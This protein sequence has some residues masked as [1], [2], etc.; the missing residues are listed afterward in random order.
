LGFLTLLVFDVFFY[1]MALALEMS[2]LL[3]LRRR[4][5]ARAGLFVMP[6]GRPGLYA[7]AAA[8]MATWLAT[9]GFATTQ[10]GATEVAIAVALAAGT[11]PAY[12]YLRHRYGGPLAS[13]AQ[14]RRL[15]P[16]LK[17]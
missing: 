2:A 12:V 3:R 17:Q 6:G 8:P 14:S 9:F 1:M 7:V 10:A 15:R 11:W 16:L 5:P 13:S 4:Y